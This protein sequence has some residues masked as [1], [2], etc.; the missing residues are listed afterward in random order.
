MKKITI[1]VKE[2][3][4][5]RD[6]ISFLAENITRFEAYGILKIAAKRIMIEMMTGEGKKKSN[7]TPRRPINYAVKGVE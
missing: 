4:D 3:E 5:G 6:D 7:F 2:G 1:D